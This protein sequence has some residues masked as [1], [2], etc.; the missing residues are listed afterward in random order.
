MQGTLPA[1]QDEITWVPTS[2]IA[3]RAPDETLAHAAMD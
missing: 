3:R 2:D 1:S